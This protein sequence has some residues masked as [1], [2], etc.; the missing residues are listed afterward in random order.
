M[1]TNQLHYCPT[2]I[3]TFNV[4]GNFQGYL[5][6]HHEDVRKLIASNKNLFHYFT[7]FLLENGVYIKK[8]LFDIKSAGCW[9]YSY[10]SVELRFK[11]IWWMLVE[12]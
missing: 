2:T 4:K 1:T 8:S 10:D 12:Q 11:P 5:V 3:S 9:F 6:C 7:M